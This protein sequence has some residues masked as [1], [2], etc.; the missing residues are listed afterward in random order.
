MNIVNFFRGSKPHLIKELEDFYFQNFQ[1]F[2][3]SRKQIRV[4]IKQELK[5]SKMEGMDSLPPN[6]GDFMLVHYHLDEY[7]LFKQIIY[8]AALGDANLEDIRHWWNLQ[9]IERRMINWED[10][11][12]RLATF[13][14]L[15]DEGL[16]E[17]EALEKLRT[18]F[19][20]Y[21]DPN[22]ESNMSGK[23]RPLPPELH[24]RVNKI[25]SELSEASLKEDVKNFSSMNSFLRN[26]LK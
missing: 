10:N 6:F 5:K 21:G 8:K 18:S 4:I 24:N 20:L 7:E 23:D 22:D 26:K 2:G 1:S 15:K 13:R 25:A 14:S 12:S 3:F 9:D 19:P 11:M 16:S 17:D